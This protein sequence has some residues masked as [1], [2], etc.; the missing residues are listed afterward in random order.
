ML[1]TILLILRWLV[2]RKSLVDLGE[3]IPPRTIPCYPCGVLCVN[4]IT[5]FCVDQPKNQKSTDQGKI[6][7]IN[8]ARKF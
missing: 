4:N 2:N 6:D 3:I 8:R 1:N 5:L 7:Q